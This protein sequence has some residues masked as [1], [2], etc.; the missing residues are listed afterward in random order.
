[1]IFFVFQFFHGT[2]IHISQNSS[3]PQCAVWETM[4]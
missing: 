2:S 3:V 4:H 1:M